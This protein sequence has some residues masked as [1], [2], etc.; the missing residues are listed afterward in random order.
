MRAQLTK[1]GNSVAVRLPKAM[2]EAA[3]LQAGDAVELEVPEGGGILVRG[4]KRWPSIDERIES[5]TPET[6]HP[7]TETGPPVGN[8]LW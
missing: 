8:E 1:W 5:I 2:L 6:L 7:E 3:K 4:Q